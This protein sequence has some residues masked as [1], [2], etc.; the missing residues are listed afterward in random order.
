M[1]GR[2]WVFALFVGVTSAH[3][4]WECAHTGETREELHALSAVLFEA[5][6]GGLGTAR[7]YYGY[8][9]SAVVQ[10]LLFCSS[11]CVYF[12]SMIL[13][14]WVEPK[15]LRGKTRPRS[16]TPEEVE[17]AGSSSSDEDKL[18]EDE[19]PAGAD[20]R[21]IE[22]ELEESETLQSSRARRR[23]VAMDPVS[24]TMSTWCHKRRSTAEKIKLVQ[25]ISIILLIS[26]NVLWWW[27]DI[28]QVAHYKLL[29]QQDNTCLIKY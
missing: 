15:A 26:A 2:V 22:V 21:G 13:I 3:E 24:G 14:A 25:R 10:L 11:A 12:C 19:S 28:Y 6:L 9:A 20:P 4:S 16:E 5:F 18:D 23:V 17:D 29:P 1:E 7:F 27:V 8:T